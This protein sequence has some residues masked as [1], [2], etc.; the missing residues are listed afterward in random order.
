MSPT[1]LA[2]LTAVAA[3]TSSL[4]LGERRAER[5]DKFREMMESGRIFLPRAE[6]YRPPPPENDTADALAFLFETMNREHNA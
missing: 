5:W 2:A 4:D 6:A 3:A 1:A